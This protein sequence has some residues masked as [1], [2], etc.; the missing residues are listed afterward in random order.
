MF[1]HLRGALPA[2]A[3]AAAS[4]FLFTPVASAAAAPIAAVYAEYGD[5]RVTLLDSTGHASSIT[6][7]NGPKVLSPSDVVLSPDGSTVY[8][9]YAAS[10]V[11]VGPLTTGGL[12]AI[13][14]ATKQQKVLLGDVPED[15]YAKPRLAVSRDGRTAFFSVASTVYRVDLRS[16][17]KTGPWT[18]PAD[19]TS[20]VV[21]PD[22]RFLYATAGNDLVKL[23]AATGGVL[24][25]LDLGQPTGAIRLTSDGTTAYVIG[26]TSNSP[27]GKL[28]KVDLTTFTESDHAALPQNAQL[29]HS[30]A[31]G[32]ALSPDESLLYVVGPDYQDSEY[33]A[34]P[35]RASDLHVG[36]EL[37]LLAD[38]A[39]SQDEDAA[40]SADGKTL[41]SFVQP[42]QTSSDVVV[43]DVATNTPKI[44]TGS[45]NNIVA[46]TT[47]PDEAP[48]AKF[49]AT[50]GCAGTATAFDASSSTV[51]QGKIVRYAWDFADGTTKVTTGPKVKHTYAKPGSYAATVTETDSAGTS[52]TVV[53]DGQTVLRNGKPT[54]RAHHTV[55]ITACAVSEPTIPSSGS[56][57]ASS[58]DASLPMTGGNTT[59]A[60]ILSGLLI[61]A[62]AVL[63]RAGRRVRG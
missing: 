39:L 16:G 62:G 59:E 56:M 17:R 44:I 63:T 42:R 22:G 15:A 6:I 46:V 52:T 43:V 50:A 30:T 54:A 3:L 58:A 33:I 28:F 49:K 34:V 31:M 47:P 53:F 55:T 9:A 37:H 38:E 48:L 10:E 2:C 41:Y 51:A 25:T 8:V 11:V 4:L 14:V 29:N 32:L 19:L 36:S 13:D 12:M 18:T 57:A 21:S 1:K 45:F 5:S 23:D 7:T 35:V 20:L 61:G 60:L 26:D 40:F 24:D 27:D